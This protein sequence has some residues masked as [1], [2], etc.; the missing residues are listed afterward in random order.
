MVV[1][2]SQKHRRFRGRRTYHGSH[3]KARGAGNRGGRGMAGM[4][5]HKWSYVTRYEPD[6]FGKHG[7]KVPQKLLRTG[8]VRTI[9]IKDLDRMVGSLLEKKI[10]KQEGDA[11]KINL[12]D[13]G[14]DKLIGTG[15]ATH[16]LHVEAK[17][18]S[19]N[20]EAKLKEAGG[21]ITILEKAKPEKKEAGAVKE[22]FEP[23]K[24]KKPKAA[25]EKTAKKPSKKTGAKK[26]SK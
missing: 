16:K 1:R 12:A 17:S 9:T 6:Y 15:R 14:Y 3:K 19:K 13:I 8:A 10:A 20:V 2:K 24:E 22:K 25:K 5:K 18:F 23:S 7:F 26:K 4:H 11:I 21:K